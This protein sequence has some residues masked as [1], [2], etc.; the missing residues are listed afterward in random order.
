MSLPCGIIQST[1]SR[2]TWRPTKRRFMCNVYKTNKKYYE[3]STIYECVEIL[4]KI[5]GFDSWMICLELNWF[6]YDPSQIFKHSEYV[7][8][9]FRRKSKPPFIICEHSFYG[10]FISFFELFF[11]KNR[12]SIFKMHAPRK[13]LNQVLMVKMLGKYIRT[14]LSAHL[15]IFNLMSEEC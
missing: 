5:I 11:A 4:S 12:K 7:S 6:F 9:T 1:E 3:I 2:D 15:T 13:H 10:C 8:K 14:S